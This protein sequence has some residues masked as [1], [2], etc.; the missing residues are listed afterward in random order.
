[1]T[2]VSG[3]LLG[4]GAPNDPPVWDIVI[5]GSGYGGSMAAA[6]FAGT[7]RVDPATGHRRPTQ[8]L[9]LERGRAW[10][11]GD[12]P[13]S[14]STLPGQVRVADTASG[15][16]TG[17]AEGLF[18]LRLGGD[19]MALVANG[20]GGGSLINAGVMLQPEPAE[21]RQPAFR[22][23]VQSLIDQGHVE[24]ARCELG[25]RLRLNAD[26]PPQDNTIAIHP[27][28]Q[29]QALAKA[30]ALRSLARTPTG[31]AQVTGVQDLPLTVAQGEH[32]NTAG[33]T[34]P[35]CQLC[36][37]CMTG[38]N[39]GAKNSLDANLLQR[40]VDAGLRLVTGASV[41][42]LRP[43]HQ[44]EARWALEVRHTRRDLDQREAQPRWVLARQ[45]VLAAGTLGSTELLLRSP[46]VACS[47]RLG[48]GFSCNGDNIAALHRLPH[49][50]NGSA[51]EHQPWTQRRVGPTITTGLKL[52]PPAGAPA[53]ARPFWLQEFAVPAPLGQLFDEIVTTA[54]ALHTLAEPDEQDHGSETPATLD[55]CAVDDTAMR[56]TLLVGLIGHDDA[57]GQLTLPQGR[58]EAGTLHIDWPQ[59]RHSPTLDAA[60]AQVHDLVASINQQQGSAARVVPNPQWRP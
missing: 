44:G 46:E 8:V 6:S 18:D 54:N 60:F 13:H 5:V 36:G 7:T 37:D 27:V 20:V 19:V 48:Q 9:L 51:P 43:H 42:G 56:H 53:A 38:C 3:S 49:V 24:A 14:F 35:A 1:M 50:V 29:H 21:L 12:F 30:Q 11:P 25:A 41:Q 16:V 40:A 26:A 22:A 23:L 31:A 33:L 15:R 57:Q 45:V 58:P 34:L 55:P 4:L 17:E 47:P 59:A 39:V 10:E 28:H 52:Q 32:R 2:R